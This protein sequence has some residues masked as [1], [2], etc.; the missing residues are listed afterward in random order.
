M[1]KLQNIYTIGRGV[2]N[3]SIKKWE[4]AFSGHNHF[5]FVYCILPY[6]YLTAITYVF[7]FALETNCATWFHHNSIHD[8]CSEP[9]DRLKSDTTQEADKCKYV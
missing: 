6:M 7:I 3:I 9:Y 1:N 8:K 2:R 4:M 5:C